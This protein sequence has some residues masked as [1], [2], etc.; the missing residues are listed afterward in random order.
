MQNLGQ[1]YKNSDI[2]QAISVFHNKKQVFKSNSIAWRLKAD[3]LRDRWDAEHYSL[4]DM[5]MMEKLKSAKTLSK[6]TKIVRQKE[7][8]QQYTTSSFIKYVAISDIDRHGMK[9]VSH[10]NLF[11]HQ[12]PSRAS[13]KI[14]EGDILLAVS[15]ANTGTERQA[16]ALVSKDYDGAICSN[17]FAVLR[18]ITNIDKYFLLAF[19]KTDIFIKQVRRMMT[20]HAIPCISLTN[21]GQIMVSVPNKHIQ[22]KIAKRTK[23]IITL[24]QQQ[25]EEINDLKKDLKFI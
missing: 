16:L 20:G 7:N 9:I 6:F 15:G 10:Q 1:T 5:Q 8:L 23:Q 4:K 11:P 2:D 22:A 12:L 25:Q 13:Y 19:F 21:L 18:S 14:Q 17:G 3:M 24:S